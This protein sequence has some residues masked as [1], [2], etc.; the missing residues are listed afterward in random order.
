[1]ESQARSERK[2]GNVDLSLLKKLS[3]RVYV[4]PASGAHATPLGP[5]PSFLRM[6]L[7]V[8]CKFLTYFPHQRQSFSINFPK[9]YDIDHGD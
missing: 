8:Y 7:N 6:M 1:M 9:S 5:G 3:A 4:A 2:Y